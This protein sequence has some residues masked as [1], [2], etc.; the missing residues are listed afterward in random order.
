MALRQTLVHL[1]I[2]LSIVGLIATLSVSYPPFVFFQKQ[3]WPWRLF[4]TPSQAR[5][6]QVSELDFSSCFLHLIDA[7]KSKETM[8]GIRDLRPTFVHFFVIV[9]IFGLIAILKQNRPWRSQ[10]TTGAGIVQVS[11]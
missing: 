3:N 10:E 7:Q 4:E 11:Q 6:V 1:L 5:V 2:T 9:S 8:V